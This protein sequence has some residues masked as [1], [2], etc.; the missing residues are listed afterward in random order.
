[1]I[2]RRR[3]E[4][5]EPTRRKERVFRPGLRASA[6]PREVSSP[7]QA[8]VRASKDPARTLDEP[9]A[10]IDPETSIKNTIS[11]GGLLVSRWSSFGWIIS[12]K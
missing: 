7:P 5:T 11:R 3:N 1:M 12:M 4:T 6:P 2:G 8:K 10:G 9:S